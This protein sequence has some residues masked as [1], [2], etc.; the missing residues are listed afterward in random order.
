MN[1]GRTSLLTGL[2]FVATGSCTEFREPLPAGPDAIPSP[3]VSDFY[4]V[5]HWEA[6][7]SQGR[8][9]AFEV[10]SDGRVVNGRINLH[11]ECN[12]GRWRATFDG[13]DGPIVDNAF[14][15]NQDWQAKHNGV[16]RRG[17]TTISGRFESGIFAR[18]GF[19]NSVDDIRKG[20]WPTGE[21]C[22]TI[23]GSWEGDREP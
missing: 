14:L 5:G 22:P 1:F 15:I 7:S 2:L 21:I 13:F 16:T 4:I 6:D 19:I 23:H 20:I 18:G 10:T 12:E 9:I 3:P 8:R 17:R 11:H